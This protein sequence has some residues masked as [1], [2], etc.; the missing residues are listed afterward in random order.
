[1]IRLRT[2][3]PVRS[4]MARNFTRAS[5]STTGAKRRPPGVPRTSPGFCS[6]TPSKSP[7]H[8]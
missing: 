7:P 2:S 3:S 1:L 4:R 5:I 6:P 8:S